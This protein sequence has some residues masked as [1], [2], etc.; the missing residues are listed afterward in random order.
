M[1]EN[2]ILRKKIVLILIITFLICGNMYGQ[3]RSTSIRIYFDQNSNIINDS[4]HLEELESLIN[5]L[6]CDTLSSILKVQAVGWSSPEGSIGRNIELST[7]RG[8]A[9][10]SFL[11]NFENLPDSLITIK[12]DGIAWNRLK[13]VVENQQ[14]PY[15]N[16]IIQI[17]NNYPEVLRNDQLKELDD[18]IPYN[19]LSNNIYPLLRFAEVT[20]D[21]YDQTTNS[22][23]NPTTTDAGGE[24]VHVSTIDV[25]ETPEQICEEIVELQSNDNNTRA[26]LALKTNLLFDIATAINAEIE[27]PIKEHWSIAAELIF[28]W[29]TIDNHKADSKRNRMQLLNGNLEGRYWWHKDSSDPILTGWFAGLYTGAGLYDLEYNA[30]GYQGEFFIAAGI[31][32]GYAHT[33]NRAENLRLEYSIGIGYLETHYKYYHSEFCNN[34]YWHAIEQRSGKYSWFGPTRAKISLSWLIN[35]TPKTR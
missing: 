32:G 28:P 19:Y 27:I 34:S 24:L 23:E 5:S 31:S 17:I 35:C 8:E 9:V 18:G 12:G 7:L 3:V 1:W 10:K 25:I 21:I 15:T 14:L 33:I 11:S 26:L 30:K 4:Y 6:R 16:E 13:I 22:N 29:W 20:V 2:N